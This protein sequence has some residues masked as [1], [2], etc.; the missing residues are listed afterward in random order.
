[1]DLLPAGLTATRDG[2]SLVISGTPERAAAGVTVLPLTL[3]PPTGAPV[4]QDFSLTVN[5]PPFFTG[6]LSFTTIVDAPFSATVTS[7]GWPIASLALSGALP[8]GL[9]FEDNGDG[10]ATISGAT[11][12]PAETSM[13]EVSADNG[14]ADVSATLTFNVYSD[15]MIA[16]VAD[17]SVEVG[18]AVTV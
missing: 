6:P 15:A 14:A 12:G 7:Q 18:T 3:T 17:Q 10:T 16:P 9:D 11:T 8:A 5:A 1:Y 4:T 13:I 2:N